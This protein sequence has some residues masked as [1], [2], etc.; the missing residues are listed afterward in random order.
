MGN[1]E[2][3]ALVDPDKGRRGKVA[4]VLSTFGARVGVYGDLD[5]LRRRWPEARC[6]M[7]HDGCPSPGEVFELM[8]EQGTWLP[9]IVYG[10]RP[11]PGRVVDAVLG[12]AMD[13]LAWPFGV[14]R[15][16]K[17][18]RAMLFRKRSFGELRR[19]A[20][21]AQ[22][23]IDRLTDRQREVLYEMAHGNS[24]K[25]IARALDISPRT[26]EIHRANMMGKLG[27]KTAH[28]AVTVA[29]FAELK[30]TGNDRD[31]RFVPEL[32]SK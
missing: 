11:Q 20:M 28:E 4:K 32:L 2:A 7:L 8:V 21:N 13:Y 27:A 14:R 25:L 16:R 1:G 26:V 19:R 10:E 31:E 23:L 15:L 29:L 24:N 9:V 3:V 5:G 22:K 6:L 30:Y 12:G 18:M 17:R